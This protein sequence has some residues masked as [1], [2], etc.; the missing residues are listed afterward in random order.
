VTALRTAAAG[1]YADS[2]LEP[3][4]QAMRRRYFTPAGRDGS[5]SASRV[6]DELRSRLLFKRVN[7]ATPPF[8]M[9]GELDVI[10]CRNVMI[11]FDNAVRQR[12]V[13]ELERLLKPGGLLV[14]AH[15]ETLNGIRSGLRA[16]MPSVYRKVERA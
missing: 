11:Y 7:L 12:L 9:R 14:V 4:P 2:R 5:E 6:A 1:V 3:V 16:L 8:P 10:F 13:Q 15:S